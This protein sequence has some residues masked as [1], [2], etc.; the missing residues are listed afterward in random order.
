MN[1]TQLQKGHEE[2]RK[3]RSESRWLLR[4]AALFS[5][6]INLLML[7]G[8]LYML[9]IYDRVLG[10][11]SEETL[12]ALSILM[13]FLFAAMGVLEYVRGRVLARIAA[14][15]QARLEGRVFH[16][17][18][19]KA[20]LSPRPDLVA[21]SLRDLDAVQRFVAAPVF[22]AIFDIPFSPLFLAGILIFHPYLGVLALVG[23]GVLILLAIL[24]QVLTR[25]PAQQATLATVSAEQQALQI[26]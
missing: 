17:V 19:A 13:A 22:A 20:A 24:N 10:S 6:F 25:A 18:L 23:G 11:R 12:L 8:P 21:N 15:L 1:Q 4:A 14:A 9:Q 2:L 3:I 26:K 5:V 16:A 7:T